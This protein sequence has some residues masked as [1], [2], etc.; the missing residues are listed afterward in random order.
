MSRKDFGYSIVGSEAEQLVERQVKIPLVN[1]QLVL[2]IFRDTSSIEV[3][4][5]ALETMTM[6]F[7]EIESGKD[8]V[9]SSEGQAIISSMEIGRVK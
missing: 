1:Q 2:E 6:T 9:F 7:Y 8:I 5:N 3:F 4:L